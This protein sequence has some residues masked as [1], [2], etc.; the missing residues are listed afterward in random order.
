M[1][2]RMTFIGSN[3]SLTSIGQCSA[4]INLYEAIAT[5]ESLEIPDNGF[6][7]V[8]WTQDSGGAFPDTIVFVWKKDVPDN[9]VNAFIT[10]F[11]AL[12]VEHNFQVELIEVDPL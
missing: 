6:R 10:A 12:A 4:A 7:I 8:H 11:K 1:T 9:Q 5:E 3:S 2:T